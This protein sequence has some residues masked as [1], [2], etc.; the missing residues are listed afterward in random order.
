MSKEDRGRERAHRDKGRENESE[1]ARNRVS[2]RGRE[3]CW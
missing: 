2:Y 3:R 1:R